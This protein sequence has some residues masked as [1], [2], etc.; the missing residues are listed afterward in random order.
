[1]LFSEHLAVKVEQR[2]WAAATAHVVDVKD[3]LLRGPV[4]A[5]RQ[6]LGT[7]RGVLG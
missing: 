6:L 7:L 2:V 4:A 3:C 1:M 5:R